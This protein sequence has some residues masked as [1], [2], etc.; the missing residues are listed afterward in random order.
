MS[1]LDNCV[2]CKECNNPANI[3]VLK[4]ANNICP[5]C[6]LDCG[7]RFINLSKDKF[8][9]QQ[10]IDKFTSSPEDRRIPEEIIKAEVRFCAKCRGAPVSGVDIYC[11]QCARCINKEIQNIEK[12]REEAKSNEHRIMLAL[13]RIADYSAPTVI[14]MTEDQAKNTHENKMLR[15]IERLAD[16]QEKQTEIFTV[17]YNAITGIKN[18]EYP[19]T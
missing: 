3:D 5:I 16:A 2:F 11:K 12:Y 17:L 4:S 7:W 8:T 9:T 6:N 13:E 19:L 10:I 18:V 14:T 1:E 15:A